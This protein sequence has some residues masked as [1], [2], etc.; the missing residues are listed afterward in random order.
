MA[1]N[2][3]R[4]L[5][6]SPYIPSLIRVRPYNFI[7]YLAR[8]GHQVT[9]LALI[10]PGE[11][12]S[13]LPQLKEWC[14]DVQT[15]SQPRW[16]TLFNAGKA[17]PSFGTPLQAAYSR[18]PEMN[19][20]VKQTVGKNQFDVLHVEHM[21]GAELVNGVTCLPIVFDSVDSITLLFEKV[22]QGGPSLKYRLMAGIEDKRNRRYEGALTGR[23]SRVLVTSPQD[24]AT[25]VE[26]SANTPDAEKNVV[27]IPNGVDLDYFNPL[28]T[29]RE[30]ETLVFS[31]KMSYHANVAAATD[32]VTQVMPLIWHHRPKVK[33]TLV[34]KD[35]TPGLLQLA[36]NPRIVVTG[37]VPDMR[38]YIGGAAVAVLPMRYGVGI[39]N[40]VLEAMAMATPVITTSAT[41]GA[42][43]AHVDRDLLA[44]DT[45]AEIAQLALILLENSDLRRKIGNAG[46][47]Y[48]QLHHDWNMAAQKLAGIYEAAWE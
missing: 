26:L 21:R 25:I 4:V 28:D 16:R 32:L 19:A 9:L 38:P 7:K 10:P 29:P 35:P 41:L 27:V 5:F 48:I 22:L 17:L 15:V 31:G 2:T 24:K 14:V 6:V 18:S 20:L 13:A 33:L 3:L 43:Q 1:K 34:G 42:L 45:P 23:F 46:R 36:N 12:T 8:Q 11:D 47:E 40:K 44:A 37:T 39:Q 30:E